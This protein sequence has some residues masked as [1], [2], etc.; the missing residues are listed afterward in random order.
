[1]CTMGSLESASGSPKSIVIFCG[2]AQGFQEIIKVVLS[3]LLD[4]SIRLIANSV[5]RI[6]P[7]RVTLWTRFC[8]VAKV[9]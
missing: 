6:F 5:E 1:M 4:A 7:G 2:G 8:T 9:V 3:E